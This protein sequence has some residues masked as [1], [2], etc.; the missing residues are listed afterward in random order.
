MNTSR[1]DRW[2]ALESPEAVE[3]AATRLRQMGDTASEARARECWLDLLAAGAGERILDVGAGLGDMTV[4]IARQVG[5]DGVVHALD[6]SA[7]LLHRARDLVRESGVSDRVATEVGDARRLPYGDGR[8]DAV[9]CRWLLLHVSDPARVVAEMRR[10]VR[11]GGRV[12]LVE[13]DWETL[14]VYPGDPATTRE[15]VQANVDRQVDGRIGRRLVPLLRSAGLQDVT[16]TP[17]VGLDLAGEWL[18]FLRSRVDVAAEAGL[19]DH[20]L[21]RWWE[22]VVS[23]ADRGDYMMSFTQYGASGTV[24]DGPEA[25]HFGRRVTEPR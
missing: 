25:V 1:R 11:P 15:I 13:A 8:F 7:G 6:L 22:A 12:L 18:P 10:V 5:S 20:D 2:A 3:A 24:P 4:V 9:F 17:L 14:A 23:A 21:A 19:P 16:V